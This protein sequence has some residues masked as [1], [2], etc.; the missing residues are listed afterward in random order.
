LL[1]ERLVQEGGDP[2]AYIADREYELGFRRQRIGSG[3]RCYE[4]AMV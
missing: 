4:R 2:A 1:A 3:R